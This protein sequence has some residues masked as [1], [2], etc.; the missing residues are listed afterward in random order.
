MVIWLGLDIIRQQSG[1]KKEGQKRNA[2]SSS[3]INVDYYVK[4]KKKDHRGFFTKCPVYALFR[5]RVYI[6]FFHFGTFKIT[7]NRLNLDPCSALLC[8]FSGRKNGRDPGRS[9]LTSEPSPRFQVPYHSVWRKTVFWT[10]LE[11][12]FI[13]SD[14]SGGISLLNVYCGAA[15]V[16]VCLWSKKSAIRWVFGPQTAFEQTKS[17][18]PAVFLCCLYFVL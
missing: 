8:F 5:N 15:M 6:N 7:K 16:E 18:Q 3:Q 12:V 14:M 1:S 10:W 9:N 17:G 13:P 2:Q 11:E 4:K